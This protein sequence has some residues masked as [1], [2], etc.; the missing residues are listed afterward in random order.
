[1][2]K[3]NR[4]VSIPE[5]LQELGSLRATALATKELVESLAGQRGDPRDA[6]VTWQDLIDLGLVIPSEIP[7][8]IGSSGFQRAR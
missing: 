1:V 4:R 2:F 5:P 6:A 3:L 7:Q 8:G